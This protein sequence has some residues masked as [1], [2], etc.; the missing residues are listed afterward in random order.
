MIAEHEIYILEGFETKQVFICGDIEDKKTKELFLKYLP[1]S[2]GIVYS[3]PPWN[4]G[5]ATYW[6]THANKEPC[7]DYNGFLDTFCKYVSASINRGATDIFTEQSF[8]EKHRKIYYSAVER[9]QW[10]L[11]LIDE[12]IVYYGSPG[13]RSVKRPNS[14]LHYGDTKLTT[15]PSG[16]AG[17]PMTIR[18]CASLKKR[19]PNGTW[20]VD[21]C[22]GKGMTSRMA[23]YFQWNCLGIEINPKRLQKAIDWLLNRGFKKVE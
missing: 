17:E 8:N 3:D 19:H 11:P 20:I 16:L 4:H 15:N 10:S 9:A 12:K 21:P 13:S 1:L 5:N 18:V 23:V 6:R 2:V 14:L 22:I 7:E